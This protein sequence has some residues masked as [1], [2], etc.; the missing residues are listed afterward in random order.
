MFDMSPYRPAH[1]PSNRNGSRNDNARG[2]SSG[3]PPSGSSQLEQTSGSSVEAHGPQQGAS[4]QGSP[5]LGSGALSGRMTT[6][7]T[8]I[9]PSMQTV[10]GGSGQHDLRA[11]YARRE[12]LLFVEGRRW[13]E[14]A[15]GGSGCGMCR[16]YSL[17]MIFWVWG[18]G[19]CILVAIHWHD[20][21][22]VFVLKAHTQERR[23]TGGDAFTAADEHP[24]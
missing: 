2:S 14:A 21:V 1:V 5:V 11:M 24:A 10:G 4:L 9:V 17:L 19:A 15:M 3:Q 8:S 20:A 12:A 16:G 6:S 18:A 13:A 22:V 23:T 7:S